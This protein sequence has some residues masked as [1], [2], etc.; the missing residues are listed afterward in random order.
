MNE[1]ELLYLLKHG[2]AED[3]EVMT[4]EMHDKFVRAAE[5]GEYPEG[6]EPL[7]MYDSLE[8]AAS[9]QFFKWFLELDRATDGK[10]VETMRQGRRY[11]IL[12]RALWR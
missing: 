6:I 3:M 1:D 5:A 7:E 9:S 2:R 12:R 4:E 8:E 10:V 11:E